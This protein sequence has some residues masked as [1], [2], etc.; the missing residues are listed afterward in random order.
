M[1]KVVNSV[2]QSSAA[3]ILD[4]LDNENE[5]ARNSSSFNMEGDGSVEQTVRGVLEPGC[6]GIRVR[7]RGV[8]VPGYEGY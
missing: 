2:P 1:S 6:E 7:V 3:S 5:E 8:L 4:A